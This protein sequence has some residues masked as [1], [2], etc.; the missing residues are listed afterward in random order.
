VG[1]HKGNFSHAP[2]APK[3]ILAAI[4]LF[5]KNN[6][7]VPAQNATT[8]NQS[9]NLQKGTYVVSGNIITGTFTNNSIIPPTQYSFTGVFDSKTAKFSGT[10]GVGTNNLNA[11]KIKTQKQL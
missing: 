6:K 10:F 3:N 1:N 9:T 7:L 8:I 4:L 5:E 11:G 2:F